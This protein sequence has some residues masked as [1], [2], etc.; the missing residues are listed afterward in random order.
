MIGGRDGCP[1]RPRKIGALD[2]PRN[3][4]NTRKGCP[5]KGTFLSPHNSQKNFTGT[6][7]SPLLEPSAWFLGRLGQPSL[8]SACKRKFK[9]TNREPVNCKKRCRRFALP[10]QSIEVQRI[11]CSLCQTLGQVDCD[12]RN[13]TSVYSVYSVVPIPLGQAIAAHLKLETP[14]ESH[15]FVFLRD[16]L[17]GEHEGG[18]AEIDHVVA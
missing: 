7:M 10:P 1:S 13:S 8:P 17:D 15:A 18:G 5:R 3:T 12:R 9:T 14:L 16:A 6:G 4:Q 11:H 2:K